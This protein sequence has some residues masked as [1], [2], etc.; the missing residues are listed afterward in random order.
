M[1][2]SPL[3]IRA[4]REER[5][6]P[7]RPS[8]SVGRASIDGEG[9]GEGS[10]SGVEFVRL[11]LS[12]GSEQPSRNAAGSELSWKRAASVGRERIRSVAPRHVATEAEG[13]AAADK[14]EADNG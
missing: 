4:E 2:R 11:D 9:A 5:R 8:S 14:G 3:D 7:R 1:R 13:I 6:D 12:D 10:D